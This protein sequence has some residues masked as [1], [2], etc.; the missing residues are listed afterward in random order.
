ML[1]RDN[2]V[3]LHM[4]Y[5]TT[6]LYI[7]VPLSSSV[8]MLRI[9]ALY[10]LAY[11]FYLSDVCVGGQKKNSPLDVKTTILSFFSCFSAQRRDLYELI[12]LG[13]FQR[14]QSRS[15]T[16]ESE[17]MVTTREGSCYGRQGAGE[18][19][20]FRALRRRAFYPL[21]MEVRFQHWTAIKEFPQKT[22]EMA[23]RA[24]MNH[25]PF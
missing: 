17:S 21:F 10:T 19:C 22:N 20:L 18:A 24:K 4:H 14:R 16:T 2:T 5:R 1:P 8:A 25:V 11:L 15:W 3:H 23:K 6:I 13:F 9:S 12:D 7:R